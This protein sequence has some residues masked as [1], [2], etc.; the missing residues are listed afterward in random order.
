[1]GAICISKVIEQM[2]GVFGCKVSSATDEITGYIQFSFTKK[3]IIE[4]FSDLFSNEEKRQDRNADIMIA[5]LDIRTNVMMDD[6]AEAKAKARD[7]LVLVEKYQGNHD[8]IDFKEI[9]QALRVLVD[10]IPPAVYSRS[11]GELTGND[12]AGSEERSNIIDG[13][14]LNSSPPAYQVETNACYY[15]TDFTNEQVK[16]MEDNGENV[17]TV[18]LNKIFSYKDTVSDDRTCGEN[19]SE[20]KLKSDIFFESDIKVPSPKKA[21]PKGF[22]NS[23]SEKEEFEI[24]YLYRV[25]ECIRNKTYAVEIVCDADGDV[26]DDNLEALADTIVSIE[27]LIKKPVF[28]LYTEKDYE[29]FYRM[30]QRLDRAFIDSLVKWKSLYY[31]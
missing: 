24:I 20:E 31:G 13:A 17:E 6:E 7:F 3:N 15:P 25:G 11:S 5:L 9:R 28:V 4:F 22:S 18:R 26:S 29:E 27:L 2:D 10:W 19:K 16:A 23:Q 12:K 21:F 30:S 1:M 14:A 8:L